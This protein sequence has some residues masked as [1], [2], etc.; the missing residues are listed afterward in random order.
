MSLSRFSSRSGGARFSASAA[1]SVLGALP[2]IASL[3][4]PW[5]GVTLSACVFSLCGSTS[6]ATFSIVEISGTNVL[7]NL[8]GGPFSR[9][10]PVVSGY[11]HL[12]LWCLGAAGFGLLFALYQARWR[13]QQRGLLTRPKRSL[14]GI[15]FSLGQLI[16]VGGTAYQMDHTFQLQSTASIS[17]LHV[18]PGSYTQ[19]GPLLLLSGLAL[20][21]AAALL[22][23]RA[24]RRRAG[25]A[26]LDASGRLAALSGLMND[27][28]GS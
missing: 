7:L 16:I 6:S 11:A 25:A 10:A 13:G 17:A 8:L 9:L 18:S 22:G 12:A 20:L 28:K 1:L 15:L 21:A 3:F 14:I 19:T 5:L 24:P 2:V 23:L 26:P 4:F 27:Q